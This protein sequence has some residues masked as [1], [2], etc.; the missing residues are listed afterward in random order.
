M[1]RRLWFALPLVLAAGVCRPVEAQRIKLPFSLKE[2]EARVRTD[3]LDP[4]AH[5]N[6]ALA[7]WNEKRYDDAE[8]DLK[9]AAA[10]DPKF[11]EAYLALAFLPYARRPKLWKEEYEDK[12]PSELKPVVEESDRM[13]RRAFLVNPLV[14]MR[15]IG[16]VTQRPDYVVGNFYDFYFRA[17]DD[18]Q[19]G[20]YEQAYG[21]FVRMHRERRLAGPGQPKLP[22]SFRWFEAL[23]AAHTKRYDEAAASFQLLIDQSLEVER[24]LEEKELIRI[25]LRTNEYRYFL[26]TV[27]QAAGEKEK[28]LELFQGVLE[29]DIGLYMAHVQRANIYESD[30]RYAEALEERQ[31]AINANPDDPSLLTDLGVTLGKAGKWQEAEETLKQAADANP[32]DPR[33]FFWMGLCQVEQGEREEAKASLSRFIATAPSRWEAQINLANQRLLRLN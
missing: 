6:V 33:P 17:F 7:Y 21:R 18:V 31:R 9:L 25:P 23:A 11:A 32:R 20:S 28:A 1:I 14:D 5:Y 15:I 27:Q 13:Y 16:A 26:A 8:R 10:M 30:R 22:L 24:K 12:V 2:L 19:E 4:A 3:S 29:A